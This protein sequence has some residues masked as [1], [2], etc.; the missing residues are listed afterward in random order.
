MAVFFSILD[1]SD[2]YNEEEKYNKDSGLAAF[3]VANTEGKQR[4]YI[5]RVKWSGEGSNKVREVTRIATIDLN[6]GEVA[7][8]NAAD[9]VPDAE[10][11]YIGV[12]DQK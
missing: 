8:T 9:A 3:R 11:P 7:L 12:F 1:D 4:L 10:T 5:D 6:S 2:S